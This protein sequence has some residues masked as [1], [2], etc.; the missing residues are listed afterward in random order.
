MGNWKSTVMLVLMLV[1]MQSFQAYSYGYLWL[2]IDCGATNTTFDE[3]LNRAWTTDNEFIGSGENKLVS[4]SSSFPQMNTLR[5]FPSGI[6][7]CYNL[8]L[9]KESKYLVRAGFYYG[10]YDNLKK[11]PAFGLE[12]Q[13]G[14]INVNVLTS[15]SSDP[16]YHEFIITKKNALD[17]CLIQTQNNQI[18]FIST[19][20][21]S[22]LDQR[23]YRLMNNSIALYLESRI[24]YG[25]NQSVPDR[26]PTYVD[27]Y[28]RIW[29]PEE[30]STSR[31][32][33]LGIG[34]T[35]WDT[36]ENNPP[37]VVL[38]SAIEANNVSESIFLPIN[39]R[40]KSLVSAYFVLYF[41][42]TPAY[43]EGEARRKVAI[44][45][46][47]QL[48]NITRLLG[49]G[50]CVTVSIFPV[51]ITGGTANLTNSPAE[52]ATSPALLNAMEVFSVISSADRVVG[53][54][55]GISIVLFSWIA[56]W[57]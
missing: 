24:N 16:I 41:D 57:I 7:N 1:A 11:P 23:V 15:L 40:E 14:N 43:Q 45:I 5:I 32:L 56:Y 36:S 28:N 30:V 8:P 6:K 18:P 51:I 47:G 20:E 19:L 34:S 10:N 35:S 31:N 22:S 12:V 48:L 33:S 52:G 42:I 53:T 49:I 37:N 46:D 21:V 2:S 25:A 13:S 4:T 26:F 55:F 38:D 29:K 17:V 3:K 54:F 9:E 39:F 27:I 44:S 50:R